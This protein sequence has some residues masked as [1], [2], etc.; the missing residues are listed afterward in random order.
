M[1]MVSIAI[2]FLLVG[3]AS[4]VDEVRLQES[5]YK[6]Q[7]AKVEEE[8]QAGRTTWVEAVRR[9]RDLDKEHAAESR[10]IRYLNLNG[11]FFGPAW[12]YNEKDE[13]YYSYCLALAEKVDNGTLTFLEF[14]HLRIRKRNELSGPGMGVV[15]AAENPLAPITG[16]RKR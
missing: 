2:G 12:V 9:I 6:R 15:D 3:C 1:K 13:E 16:V 8:A 10:T 14:D 7:I 11:Y 5:Q 4:G